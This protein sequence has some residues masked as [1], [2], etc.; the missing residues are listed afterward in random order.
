MSDSDFYADRLHDAKAAVNRGDIE[1][2]ADITFHALL[3]GG[4]T[5]AENLAEL[6]KTTQG[7]LDGRD[8]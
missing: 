7:L 1:G 2:A 5:C 8:R 4:G 3:E 6:N